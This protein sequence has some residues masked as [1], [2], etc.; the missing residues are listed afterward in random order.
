MARAP[1]YHEF[2]YAL[3]LAHAKLGDAAQARKHLA[4]AMESS[5]TRGD[6][7]L[8]AAKLD[9]IRAVQLH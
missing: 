8:Y 4:L 9:K 5:T 3:A 6:H 2:H 1:Y 7:D